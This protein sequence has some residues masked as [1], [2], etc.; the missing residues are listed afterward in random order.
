METIGDRVKFV[1]KLLGL[2]QEELAAK[3]GVAKK[4]TISR[5]EKGEIKISLDKI[6]KISA[7]SFVSTDWFVNGSVGKNKC[8]WIKNEINKRGLN[9]ELFAR[10]VGIPESIIINI[11]EYKLDASE[12]CV[13]VIKT[14]FDDE[15][16]TSN[17]R[18]A[19]IEKLGYFKGR[20]EQ[21]EKQLKIY[22]DIIN[23]RMT[24]DNR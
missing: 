15:K 9:A 22:E 10:K 12:A 21:L 20:I 24:N 7:R 16:V 13:N 8:D 5:Y 3:I 11:T 19:F 1:R 14:R 17:E 23:K 18:E 4:A 2:S 6:A